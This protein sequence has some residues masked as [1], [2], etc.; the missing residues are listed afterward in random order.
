M[1]IQA[2]YWS[3]RFML[4]LVNNSRLFAYGMISLARHDTQNN[5]HP[6]LLDLKKLISGVLSLV[7]IIQNRTKKYSVQ[8]RFVHL[9]E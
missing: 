3:R 7:K 6:L 8:G 2:A 9:Y 1:R 4:T 5:L